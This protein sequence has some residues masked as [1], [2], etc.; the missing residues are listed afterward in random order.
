[1]TILWPGVHLDYHFKAEKYAF[2]DKS[3][4]SVTGMKKEHPQHPEKHWFAQG[5]EAATCANALRKITYKHC[6]FFIVLTLTFSP[7]Q[8]I[9]TKRYLLCFKTMFQMGILAKCV[10]RHPKTMQKPLYVSPKSWIA[11]SRVAFANPC[12][13]QVFRRYLGGIFLRICQTSLNFTQNIT[14]YALKLWSKLTSGTKWSNASRK[15]KT[16]NIIHL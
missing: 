5:F 9:C 3:K 13:N 4:G 11:Y 10:K 2:R 16:S 7:F 6:C 8:G 14:F 12:A 15:C 1:M